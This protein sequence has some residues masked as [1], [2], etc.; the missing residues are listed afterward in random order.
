LQNKRLI[1]LPSRKIPDQK[2]G[3]F[4]QFIF[5]IYYNSFK[6]KK[7]RFCAEKGENGAG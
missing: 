5:V 1:H 6:E 2:N 3:D 4:K 7:R